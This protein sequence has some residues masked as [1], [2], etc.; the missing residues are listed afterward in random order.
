MFLPHLVV[1][2]LPSCCVGVSPVF[3]CV[4][5]FDYFSLFSL[6]FFCPSFHIIF[7]IIA[8][9]FI[10]LDLSKQRSVSSVDSVNG[11]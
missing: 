10:V 1:A 9:F 4:V 5:S 7:P 8:L 2:A 3:I 6:I 11:F